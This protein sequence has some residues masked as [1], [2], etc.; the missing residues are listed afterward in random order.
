MKRI[1]LL[2]LSALL[3]S[4]SFG[5]DIDGKV[6]SSFGFYL[7]PDHDN[8][9]ATEKAANSTRWGTAPFADSTFFKTILGLTLKADDTKVYWETKFKASSTAIIFEPAY[10]YV[11]TNL[12]NLPGALRVGYQR[13]GI[14]DAEIHPYA[15]GSLYTYC[16]DKGVGLSYFVP[17]GDFDVKVSQLGN[18]IGLD[19]SNVSDATS[20]S[21]L[22]LLVK[23]GKEYTLGA[24]YS[25]DSASKKS[26]FSLYGD[27][28][29]VLLENLKLTGVYFM[30]L[31]DEAAAAHITAK[32][33]AR[34][35]LGVYASYSLLSDLDVYANLFLDSNKVDISNKMSGGLKYK[36]SSGVSGYIHYELITNIKDV[37]YS[38]TSIAFETSI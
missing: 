26:G 7:S 11:D 27:Y 5:L 37:Q 31:N 25:K 1:A 8:S 6:K 32:T 18:T 13:L 4:L 38:T 20:K 35:D 10:F 24:I 19:N 14:A 22:G 12:K 17:V 16:K 2:T 28:T 29:T 3:L 15:D 23:Y 9:W 33:K 34:S 30:D 36:L 21:F